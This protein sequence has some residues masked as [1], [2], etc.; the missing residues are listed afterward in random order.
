MLM[1][2]TDCFV[3]KRCECYDN[4]MQCFQK[5]GGGKFVTHYF[6]LTATALYLLKIL[7]IITRPHNQHRLTD[8]HQITFDL[9]NK[10]H[11]LDF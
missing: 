2:K 4:L 5:G 7:H 10:S 11:G 6:H 8:L 9:D 3:G 1:G